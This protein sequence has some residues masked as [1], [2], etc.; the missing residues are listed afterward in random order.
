MQGPWKAIAPGYGKMVLGYFGKTPVEPD[1]EVVKIASEQL[2]LEPTTEKA[3]DLADADPAK[4]L[5]S[6]INR[7]KDEDIEITEEN[8]FIAAA[9]QEKGIAFLKGEG[10]LKVRKISE[11]KK[12]CEEGS[13][14]MGSGNY[15]VV[16]DGQKF[17]V[18]VAEGDADI[19]VT[20]VNGES[21]APAAAATP[22]AASGEGVDIK[23]LLPG[24]VWKIVANPGQSVNEGD[25]I[26]ILESMKMEIDV[27]APK[28]GV[29]KSINVATN[30]KVVEGQVV[31]VLG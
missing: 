2:K 19:Q 1:P 23:A 31:A 6:W 25:V 12:D 3:L 24:N 26:M 20:A 21:A 8:I 18:Q 7:L 29:I 13:S 15:T 9:C 14:K 17:S 30:D 28:G 16:V 27:V 4:S 11:M 5:E 10:E 22:A